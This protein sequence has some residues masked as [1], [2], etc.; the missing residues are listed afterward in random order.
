MN[1]AR[2]VPI[3]WQ[4][5]MSLDQQHPDVVREFHRGNFFIHKSKREFSALAIDQA[6][7]QNSAV[8]KGDG[9]MVE[10]LY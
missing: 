2:W 7:E 9:V 6:H 8:I 4:D 10:L 5:M 3:H 1:Y